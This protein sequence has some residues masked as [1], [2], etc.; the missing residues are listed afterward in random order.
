[1]QAPITKSERLFSDS[2]RNRSDFYGNLHK[3]QATFGLT[4]GFADNLEICESEKS[5]F[6]KFVIAT[7]TPIVI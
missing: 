7:K 3:N 5:P 1:N 4:C 2:S 6:A